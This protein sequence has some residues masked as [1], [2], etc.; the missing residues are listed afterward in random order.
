VKLRPVLFLT[1]ACLLLALPVPAG[2][3][4]TPNAI[5]EGK[6]LAVIA[7]WDKAGRTG[8]LDEL[9]PY[10]AEDI[11]LK[12]TFDVL[13]ETKNVE[14]G[15]EQFISQSKSGFAKRVAYECKRHKTDVT[16]S[17]DGQSAMVTSDLFEELTTRREAGIITIKT[18]SSEVV[19]LKLQG[20][21]VVVTS[22]YATMGLIP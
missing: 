7:A 10:L 19:V 5:T 8:K 11:Q 3:A 21:K 2:R 15:R 4:Q 14:M 13:G 18:M 12:V 22:Y 1:L 17:K 6:V 20:G 9:I 16:I